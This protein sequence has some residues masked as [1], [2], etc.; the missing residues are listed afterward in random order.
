MFNNVM[1]FQKLTGKKV[2]QV[3]CS[4]YTT[5][6]LTTNGDLYGCGYGSYGLQGNG[7]TSNVTT[8]TKR[9][10]GVAQIAC[11]IDTTWYLT[12]NGDLCG[13]GYGSFGQQGNGSTSDVTTFTK[14]N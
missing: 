4:Q 2:A 13:C 11:S 3:A 14:R 5:W 12:T 1:L 9:A 10:S 8:F 7:T 6:Y